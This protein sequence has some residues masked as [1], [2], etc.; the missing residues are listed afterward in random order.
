MRIPSRKEAAEAALRD[1][2]C[3]LK[4]EEIAGRGIGLVTTKK[5]KQGTVLFKESPTVFMQT[6]GTESTSWVCAHCMSS[7]GSLEAQFGRLGLPEGNPIPEPPGKA[8]KKKK[9][10]KADPVPC[11]RCGEEWYCSEAHRD[12]HALLHSAFCSE[13]DAHRM[14]TE[15]FRAFTRTKAH[16]Q[17][18]AGIMAAAVMVDTSGRKKALRFDTEY[19][20]APWSDIVVLPM[21]IDPKEEQKVRRQCRK[22]CQ[23][24]R[25]L[26]LKV[27]P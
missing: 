13:S 4:C 7:I 24:G 8:S 18:L 5:V 3:W 25:R 27:P 2:G 20:N 12:E 26:V 15:E 16:T 10:P 6:P 1:G 22:D 17:Y 19:V 14:A 11:E 9:K 21:G 23:E